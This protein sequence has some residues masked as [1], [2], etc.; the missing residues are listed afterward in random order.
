MTTSVIPWWQ[1]VFTTEE[2]KQVQA[3]LKSGMVNDGP[4][5]AEF[6][7]R[8]AALCDVPCA[9]A[10]P[11]CTSALFLG[12]AAFGIGPG[13]EV[14]V[15]DLTFIATANAVKLAGATPVLVDVLPDGC[16]NPQA[17]ERAITPKTKAM[18]PVHVSGH[19]ADM[20]LLLVIAKRHNLVVIEDA[21]EALGSALNGKPMGS[22]GDAGCFSFSP[23]K[24]VT[25]GQGGMIVLRHAHI[26][27][28]L[29]ELKDQGRPVRGTGGD[30]VHVSVGYNFKFTDLQAAVGLAQLDD[31]PRRLQRQ[32][33]IHRTY[34]EA[35]RDVPG[36][37]IKP[38]ALD[39]GE[40]PQWTDAEVEKR[41]ELHDALKERGMHCRRFWHPLHMQAPYKLP[42]D[43]LPA[44]MRVSYQSLWLP[45]SLTMSDEELDRVCDA[46]REICGGVKH[47]VPHG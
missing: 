12:L 17:A 26:E 5:T 42:D 28:R 22:W 44:A 39:D 10:V 45:S 34:V 4:L 32:A 21:A 18:I 20:P 33:A 3:V 16:M 31:L 11:N 25:T 46:I 38:F 37:R 27:T 47:I 40:R 1:P 19:S 29:R 9:V 14:L 35:L 6:E 41:N 15:P 7:K 8:I 23:M 13:D 36:I 24:T 2:Q 30:D 43:A